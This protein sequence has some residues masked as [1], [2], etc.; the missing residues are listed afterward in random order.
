MGGESELH[1]LARAGLERCLARV[2]R[3]STG[4]WRVTACSRYPGTAAGLFGERAGRPAAAVYLALDSAPLCALLL[5]SPAE[6]ECVSRGFTGHG[7]PAGPAVSPAEE[8]MLSE[9]GNILLNA[10]VNPLLN[11]LGKGLLPAIPWFT[12]GDAGTIPA[13]LPPGPVLAAGRR[14]L[15]AAI[16]LR[17]GEASAQLE[18]FAFLPE[19]LALEIE[20]R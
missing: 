12:D 14:I 19:E 10:F 16:D 2:S 8:I 9:L 17:C 6:L 4:T 18:L 20:N 7:F 13:R 11:A 1:A 15:R 5:A 3:S